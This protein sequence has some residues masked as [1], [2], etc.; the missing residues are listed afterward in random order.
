MACCLK[1]MVVSQNDT[2]NFDQLIQPKIE[3]EIAFRVAKDLD[4]APASEEELAAYLDTAYPAL[5]IVDS[6]I[7]DWKITLAD[8]VADNAS[9]ALFVLG[10]PRE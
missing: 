6:R 4:F 2:I 8:T 1:H 10:N 3:A 5:E 7:K 9:S